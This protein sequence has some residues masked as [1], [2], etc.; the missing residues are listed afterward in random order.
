VLLNQ[1]PSVRELLLLQTV[2]RVQFDDRLDPELGLTFGMLHVHAGAGF[3][4]EK[5]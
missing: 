1:R 2:V 3:L 4:A 5:K